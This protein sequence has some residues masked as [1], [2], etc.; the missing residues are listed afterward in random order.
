MKALGRLAEVQGIG[1]RHDIAQMTEFHAVL[2]LAHPL[3]TT[4]RL[5]QKD[6]PDSYRKRL[7]RDQTYISGAAALLIHQKNPPVRGS[8]LAFHLGGGPCIGC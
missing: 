6:E 8:G 7:S 3:K 5:S 2:S 4:G 1:H